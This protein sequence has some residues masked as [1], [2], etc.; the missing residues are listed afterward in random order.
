MP[1]KPGE[2]TSSDTLPQKQP[3]P[4]IPPA[5][6]PTTPHEE[7]IAKPAPA[8][9]A[10]ADPAPVSGQAS[11]ERQPPEQPIKQPEKKLIPA[12][13]RRAEGP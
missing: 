9:P 6:L 7:P 5:T 13:E 8:D 4:V 1:P 11:A 3:Q 10:H 12:L 2:K